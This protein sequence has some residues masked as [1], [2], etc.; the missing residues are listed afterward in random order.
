MAVVSSVSALALA[1]C[2]PHRTWRQVLLLSWVVWAGWWADSL[3]CP[4]SEVV[5]PGEATGPSL[6]SVPWP[7]RQAARHL[8]GNTGPSCRGHVLSAVIPPLLQKTWG[9]V[10]SNVM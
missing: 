8:R 6:R 10:L 5:G 4:G 2:H 9:D 3:S 7:P 1:V